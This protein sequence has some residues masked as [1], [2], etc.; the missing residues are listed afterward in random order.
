MGFRIPRGMKGTGRDVQYQYRCHVCGKVGL[1]K[2]LTHRGII[3]NGQFKDIDICRT[4]VCREAF[5]NQYVF[6]PEAKVEGRFGGHYMR[7]A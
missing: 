6:D 2:Q 1:S 5:E 7:R 4:K 3:E